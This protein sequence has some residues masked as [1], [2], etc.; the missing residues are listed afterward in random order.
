M[1]IFFEYDKRKNQP[2]AKLRTNID[3]LLTNN[4][5]CIKAWASVR[6]LVKCIPSIQSLEITHAGFG[7]VKRLNH[8][9]LHNFG[10]SVQVTELVLSSWLFD[11]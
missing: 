6:N 7:K 1:L 2:L 3:W 9:K 10:V 4:D 8:F 5:T 11:V